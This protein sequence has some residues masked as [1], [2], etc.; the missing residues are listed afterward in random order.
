M[1]ASD[2]VKVICR[3]FR[4]QDQVNNLVGQSFVVG[5]IKDKPRNRIIYLAN[6]ISQFTGY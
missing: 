1:T 4:T 5:L 6:G 2:A 3:E